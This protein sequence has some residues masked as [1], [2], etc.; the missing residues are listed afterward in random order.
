MGEDKITCT[1]GFPNF[2]EYTEETCPGEWCKPITTD[3]VFNVA[4]SSSKKASEIATDPEAVE[5]FREA[6]STILFGKPDF[7]YQ[8]RCYFTC[9][10]TSSKCCTGQAVASR[11]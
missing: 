10:A 7:S 6:G 2:A 9:D 8:V 4:I 3:V 1:L 11:I 5:G